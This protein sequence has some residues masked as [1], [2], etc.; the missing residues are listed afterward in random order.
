MIIIFI[1][2]GL[3]IGAAIASIG[4]AILGGTLGLITGMLVQLK[5]RFA[6]LSKKHSTL[7]EQFKALSRHYEKHQ[8]NIN[9]TV[10]LN[11]QSE[12]SPQDLH[13]EPIPQ[14]EQQE[15]TAKEKEAS[16]DIFED[17][18]QESSAPIPL[19]SKQA[20]TKISTKPATRVHFDNELNNNLNTAT[21]Q[22]NPQSRP[23]KNVAE[24]AIIG[25]VKKFFSEGNP[26]VKVASIVLF[27]GVAFLLKYAAEQ[28][29]I[30][31]EWR[32]TCVALVA[33]GLLVWG[34]KLI[35]K[36]RQYGL[37]VQ[38]LSI[39]VLYLTCYAASGLYSLLPLPIAFSLLLV[40]AILGAVLAIKQDSPSLAII[41]I[42]GGFLAPILTSSGS[43]AYIK[44]FS[45]YAVLNV[46]ILIISLFKSW[47]Y[48]CWLGFI[49]TFVIG[50]LWG[51]KSYQPEYFSTTEPFLLFHFLLYLSIPIL[52]LRKKYAPEKPIVQT[53]LVFALP[54]ISFLLQL[55]LARDFING[56]TFSALGW[57]I[58]YFVASF[59]I[60]K[61]KNKSEAEGKNLLT[62][63]I[64]IGV[65]FFSIYIFYLFEQDITSILWSLEAV[66]LTWLGLRQKEWL[67]KL[68]GL[69]LIAL[70]TF[71]YLENYS[72]YLIVKPFLNASFLSGLILTVSA[73][74][75]GYFYHNAIAQKSD[76]EP[77]DFIQHNAT[78]ISSLLLVFFSFFI[79]L[80]GFF[81]LQSFD[82][83]SIL[84]NGFILFI[85]LVA[86]I[87]FFIANAINWKQL[88]NLSLAIIP[89]VAL[90]A[91]ALFV[92]DP[93]QN[94]LAHIG[95]I[96]FP[97]AILSGY[98]FNK[99]SVKSSLIDN[100]FYQLFLSILIL[101]TTFIV[102]WLLA[103]YAQ[104]LSVNGHWYPIVFGIIPAVS[105]YLCH[106]KSLKLKTGDLDKIPFNIASKILL[107]YVALWLLITTFSIL[108]PENLPFVSILNPL[109][110]SHMVIIFLIYKMI[111]SEPDNYALQAIKSPPFR[112]IL[113]AALFVCINMLVARSY[114]HYSETPFTMVDLMQAPNFLLTLTILW[115]LLAIVVMYLAKTK[116][117]R[118]FWFTGAA[119]LVAILLK[120]ITFDMADSG[121]L[122][123]ILSFLI[124][125]TI[126]LAIGYFVP[127]PPEEEKEQVNP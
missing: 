5:Q 74:T 101:V 83:P 12:Q 97:I 100:N 8:F 59:V 109:D 75:I 94:P 110:I 64:A 23:K 82:K 81:E 65:I 26:I 76:Q 112:Y 48:L 70:S 43:N 125:G 90:A 95:Y 49:F 85:A 73:L 13:S 122:A 56:D 41:A 32:L 67:P 1:L 11:T 53:S 6:E 98:Y 66:G 35:K 27:F 7:D 31:I 47:R 80:L 15:N 113:P 38:G 126:M 121:T 28:N 39:G 42:I 44:L 91:I 25:F 9:Q 21:K 111:T 63:Y 79:A 72:Q 127:L 29:Y 55:Y 77:S 124:V 2:L 17:F 45:Y 99:T 86:S 96:S 120:L 36:N 16:F 34:I 37:V 61:L 89:L 102:S 87:Y 40:I 22:S 68:A 57:S 108:H 30:P 18:E 104:K 71:L 3:F 52:F 14:T 118:T 105:F 46:G 92:N 103:V 93:Y 117:S 84:L 114:H 50:S 24:P 115:S 54:T 78:L 106:L 107:A 51:Y 69:A 123:R 20:A 58:C 88:S 19:Q 4:G 62:S 60:Y 10:P 119:L 116:Q 33:V